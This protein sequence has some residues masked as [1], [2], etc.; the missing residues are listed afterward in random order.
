MER[1]LKVNFFVATYKENDWNVGYVEK[2]TDK[3]EK[4]VRN[5]LNKVKED[6]NFDNKNNKVVGYITDVEKVSG[7]IIKVVP[8]NYGF[9]KMIDA[10]DK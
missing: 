5:L 10:L 4:I 9:N 6:S 7:G 8:K 1:K 2:F 3:E